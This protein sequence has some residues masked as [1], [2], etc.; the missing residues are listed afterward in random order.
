MIAS[1]GNTGKKNSAPRRG[2]GRFALWAGVVAAA[3]VAVVAVIATKERDEELQSEEKRKGLISEVDPSVPSAPSA[4]EEAKVEKPKPVPFWEQDSTNGFSEAMIRKWKVA[5]YPPPCYTNTS[6]LTESPPSYAVFDHPSENRI[7]AYLTIE[8]GQTMVGTPVFGEWF[9]NDFKKSCE[10]PIVIVPE[11]DDET[12]ALKQLMIETKIDLMARIR[13]GG[14]L[15]DI[16]D[17]THREVQKLSAAKKEI[18]G[19]V[20]EQSM[21]AETEEELDDLIEAANKILEDKGI[22]PISANPI[23]RRNIRRRVM[24]MNQ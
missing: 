19:L 8:P 9:V 23:V 13:N 17:E 1:K 12:K 16:L 24:L 4:V 10:E 14:N 22:A 21:F 20:H 7:A 5:H 6:S 15:A 11:D 2:P 18:E 3:V